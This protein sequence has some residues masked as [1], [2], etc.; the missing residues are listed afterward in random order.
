MILA[1]GLIALASAWLAYMFLTGAVQPWHVYVIMLVRSTAGAFHWPAMQASTSLMVPKEHLPRIAGLNQALH[2]GMNIAAPPLGALLLSLLPMYGIL[3]IDI[4]T[5]TL[6]IVPLFFFFIPQPVSLEDEEATAHVLRDLQNGLRYLKRWPGMIHM[7]GLAAVVELLSVPAYMLAPI[8]VSQYFKGGAYQLGAMNSAY[9]IGFVVGGLTLSVWGGF[10]RRILTSLVGI[11]GVGIAML[12]VGFTPPSGFWVA[13]AAAGLTGAMH[14]L[15]TGPILAI[16]QTVVAPE[17]QGRI[18]SLVISMVTAMAPI[19]MIIAGPAAD[20]VGVH[21]LY[22][23]GGVGC[24]VIGI[25]SFSI[26]SITHME[27][28]FKTEAG[29][30]EPA[31]PI[32]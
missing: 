18:L 24:T 10:K 17:M 11:V 8:L 5:A 12:I 13:A 1:D 21:T 15:I 26:R 14:A 25:A 3:G 22:W 23:V 2:G 27:E 28:G 7:L 9:G 4:A 31:E 20:A 32:E 16:I 30:D 6:A 19:S 29:D